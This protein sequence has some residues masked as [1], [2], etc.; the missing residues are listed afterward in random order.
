[1]SE[2]AT[3]THRRLVAGVGNVFF[4]DDAFG[5]EV[6]RVLSTRHL[7]TDVR[8]VDYGIRGTHLAYDLLDGWDSLVLIDAVPPRGHP[9]RLKL[10][11]V[12]SDDVRT[13]AFDPHGM[14]PATVL[15]GVMSLGGTLP[16][17]VVVGCEAA[18]LRE[19]MGLSEAVAAMVPA[20]ADA[21][22][23]LLGQERLP[24]WRLM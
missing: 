22:E 19:G 23:R 8:V 16:P 20:A 14:D 9:G 12:G 18:D 2:G 6:A 5:S 17:T 24:T 1:M 15:A 13:G 10:L 3:V 4:G 21:V 11:A 7:P